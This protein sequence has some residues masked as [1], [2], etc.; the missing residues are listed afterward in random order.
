MLE[1]LDVRDLAKSEWTESTTSRALCI[2]RRSNGTFRLA[3][4]AEQKNYEYK[5]ASEPVYCYF[6]HL[7]NINFL[8]K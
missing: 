8:I 5:S 7:N 2:Y 3:P 1:N 6:T 4:Y